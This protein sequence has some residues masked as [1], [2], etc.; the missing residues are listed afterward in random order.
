MIPLWLLYTE[1]SFYMNYGL[2]ERKY[3]DSKLTFI[4][5]VWHALRKLCFNCEVHVYCQILNWPLELNVV[6][7]SSL[8]EKHFTLYPLRKKLT[9]WLITSIANKWAVSRKSDPGYASHH[10]SKFSTHISETLLNMV[11]IRL[12]RWNVIWNNFWANS[13]F[14]IVSLILVEY[15]NWIIDFHRFGNPHH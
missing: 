13:V 2:V 4:S 15:L 8:S 5:K 7:N 14:N 12:K 10:S 1:L 11:Q 6:E 3:T 9:T